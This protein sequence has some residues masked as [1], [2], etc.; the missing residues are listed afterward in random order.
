MSPNIGALV[1]NSCSGNG[2]GKAFPQALGPKGFRTM[3]C[4]G[5]NI[6]AAGPVLR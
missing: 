6:S 3:Y 4:T 2:Q 5:Q 1:L